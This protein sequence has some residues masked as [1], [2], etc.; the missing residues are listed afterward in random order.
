[1]MRLKAVFDKLAKGRKRKDFKVRTVPFGTAMD[2]F[3]NKYGVQW[4]FKRGDRHV[5]GYT[6]DEKKSRGRDGCF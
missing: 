3:A 6:A 1:M 5:Y 4:I 2:G